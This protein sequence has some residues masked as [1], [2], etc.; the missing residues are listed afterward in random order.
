MSRA[1]ERGK[2][3]PETVVRNNGQFATTL[4]RVDETETG[5][6][7]PACHEANRSDAEYIAVQSAC[8]PTYDLCSNPECFGGDQR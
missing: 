5:D 1:V 2:T 7:L 3:V 8:Y 4:H 6:P